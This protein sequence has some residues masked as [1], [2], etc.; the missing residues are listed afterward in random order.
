MQSVIFPIKGR[1]DEGLQIL[2]PT[3]ML[4]RLPIV[5]AQLKAGNTYK[6]FLNEIRQITYSLHWAKR[7]TKK[8]IKI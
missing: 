5:L 6:K 8:Y 2:A 4:Q 7:I 1:K 3:Q